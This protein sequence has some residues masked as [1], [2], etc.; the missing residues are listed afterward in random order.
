MGSAARV[1]FATGRER[2][3]SSML[4]TPRVIL[5][6]LGLRGHSE[7]T[8]PHHVL[9][10]RASTTTARRLGCGALIRMAGIP[11][12]VTNGLR[13]ATYASSESRIL[14]SSSQLRSTTLVG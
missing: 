4:L 11:S 10:Q 2:S 5:V 3:R 9:T 14:H 7:R 8:I 13:S 6:W 12:T 1:L